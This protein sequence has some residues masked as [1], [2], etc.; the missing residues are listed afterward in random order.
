MSREIGIPDVAIRLMSRRL[1][2]EEAYR[3]LTMAQTDPNQDSP[4]L[5]A[6]IDEAV[7][8]LEREQEW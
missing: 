3:M 1:Q 2:M 5:R 7:R 8:I 4:H 6:R